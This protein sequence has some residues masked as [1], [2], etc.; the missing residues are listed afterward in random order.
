[1][2]REEEA[3]Q[4][5]TTYPKNQGGNESPM[6]RFPLHDHTGS[7]WDRPG[8]VFSAGR[9]PG[10]RAPMNTAITAALLTRDRVCVHSGEG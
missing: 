2:P 3:T 1:M 6:S 9:V 5:I 10:H 8:H 7:V 4:K